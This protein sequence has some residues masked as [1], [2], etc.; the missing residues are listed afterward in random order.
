MAYQAAERRD[1]TRSIGATLTV[2]NRTVVQLVR[3]YASGCHDYQVLLSQLIELGSKLGVCAFSIIAL[4]SLCELSEACLRRSLSSELWYVEKLSADERKIIRLIE[5][6][7]ISSVFGDVRVAEGVAP[8][9]A[10]SCLA[11]SYLR[12]RS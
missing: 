1:Q 10:A 8:A 7:T 5:G 9:L 6:A 11:L 4:A 2:E 3:C 12:L